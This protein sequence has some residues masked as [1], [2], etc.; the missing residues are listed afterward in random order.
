MMAVMQDTFTLCRERSRP[1]DLAH[2]PKDD[3]A[4]FELMQKAD[5]IGVFQIESRA[6]MATLPRMK[7]K[8]FYDVVIEVAIIRPGPI[9]GDMVHPYLA[10]RAGKEPVTYFDERLKPVLKRTLGVPLFQEQMLKIAM[11]MADFSGGEAEELRRAISFHRS[12]ERMEKVSVKLRAGMEKNGVRPEVILQI[13]QAISSFA[14]YGFPE[15]H[16]IS[17]AILAY[18]SAYLKVH[19]AAEFYACLLNNQPMGFYAP[20]TIVKDAERHGIRM[21]PV[22]AATSEWK[23][24]IESDEVVRLGFCIVNGLREEHAEELVRQ[25]PFTSLADLK[26]RTSLTKEELRRLAEIGAFNCFAEHRRD[27]LW[28]VEE[29]LAPELFH[30]ATARVAESSNP[31]APMTLPERVQAD[32]NGMSLTTGPHPMKLLRAQLPH[33]WCA[34]ELTQARHGATVQIA[35]NVICRQ[36]PGTAKGFVFISL[37]DETGVSNAIVTPDLF[38]QMRLLI[39]EEPFLVIEGE[40]QNSDNVVLIKARRI[41]PLA[42]AQLGGSESHDFR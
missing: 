15:S 23:C 37:E 28:K 35:G 33:A 39:T 9:Q 41:A 31:L 5:T 3:A 2:L 20:A 25:R 19:R 16:A 10:R 21:R 18:G 36:R 14:L 11:I 8:E 12:P 22:C 29:P 32:Y 42:H 30:Q 1:L 7:P 13:I 34:S 38:E 26:R 4:T 40:V 24:T 27:A 17:F 6:Q